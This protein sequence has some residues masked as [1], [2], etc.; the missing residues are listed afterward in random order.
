MVIKMTESNKTPGKI[1]TA[2]KWNILR[3]WKPRGQ[4][5]TEFALILPLLLLVLLGIVEF[6][7]ILQAYITVQHAA[8]TGARYAVTGQFILLDEGPDGVP[9]TDDDVWASRPSSIIT[10]THNAAIGLARVR[11]D[12]D[13][14]AREPRADLGYYYDVVLEPANGGVPHGVGITDTITVT[15]HYN[16][17]LLTPII[18]NILGDVVHVA[19]RA[20]MQNE[21]FNPTPGSYVY[22]LLDG[23]GGTGGTGGGGG[24][25]G[26]GGSP[27]G[28]DTPTPTATPVNCSSSHTQINI[29]GSNIVDTFTLD[30]F[31]GIDDGDVLKVV[32]DD[33]TNAWTYTINFAIVD[34]APT[35]DHIQIQYPDSSIVY[36]SPMGLDVSL[37]ITNPVTLD[38][39]DI[40]SVVISDTTT[41]D[42]GDYP[43]VNIL[44]TNAL[45]ASFTTDNGS[46]ASV[47]LTVVATPPTVTPTPTNTPP[48]TD[49][50]TPTSTPQPIA[51]N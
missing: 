18:G 6:A 39:L 9:G 33:G 44:D 40:S 4:S 41:F 32:A 35:I 43:D 22:T 10:T 36:N 27:L 48:P 37:T 16:V 30:T 21:S 5:L 49:T 8:R 14:P 42:Y 51:L 2:N 7:R 19:G 3:L 15:V 24:G 11:P 25:G 12:A 46:S 1:K 23:T 50:P 29:P 31:S 26:G 47:C 34:S 28:T 17:P 13:I 20:V 45:N 38:L